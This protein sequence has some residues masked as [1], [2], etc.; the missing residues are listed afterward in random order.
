MSTYSW[1]QLGVLIAILLVTTRVLG[2]YV[3]GVFGGGKA[4]G[5]RVFAAGRARRSTASAASIRR[6]SRRGPSTPSR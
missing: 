2:A 6:A 5:D 1:L 3:A 4:L